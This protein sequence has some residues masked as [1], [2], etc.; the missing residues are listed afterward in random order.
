MEEDSETVFDAGDGAPFTTYFWQPEDVTNYQA[1]QQGGSKEVS[2]I[3]CLPITDRWSNGNMLGV[4]LMTVF[5][6][7]LISYVLL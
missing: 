5:I 6:I 4:P 3:I 2:E 1:C 7:N